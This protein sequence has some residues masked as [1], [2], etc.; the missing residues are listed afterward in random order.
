MG[1]E[2]QPALSSVANLPRLVRYTVHSS[3]YDK[4]SLICQ[5][6]ILIKRL[7]TRAV[8]SFVSDVLQVNTEY[9]VVQ[10]S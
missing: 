7:A 8:L 5:V 4:L 10:Y 9:G 6:L 2:K 1:E 3:L